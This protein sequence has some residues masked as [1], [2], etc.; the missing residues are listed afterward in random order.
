MINGLYNPAILSHNL[1]GLRLA[2]GM[3]QADIAKA[4]GVSQNSVWKYE[5]GQA[6]PSLAVL[7]W[8]SN[9]FDVSIDNL[10]FKLGGKKH[11]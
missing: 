2:A 10:L 8:Y 7:S 6:E 9:E 3:S 1:R 11:E 4:L 5:S